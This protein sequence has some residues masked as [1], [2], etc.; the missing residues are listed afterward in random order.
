MAPVPRLLYVGLISLAD[1][2]G[3]VIAEP[4][5]LWRQLF[6]GDAT[7][8]EAAIVAARAEL[9]ASGVV[10]LYTVDGVEYIHHP[11]FPKHQAMNRRYAPLYPLAPEQEYERTPNAYKVSP[12]TATARAAAPKQMRLKSGPSEQDLAAYALLH[13]AWEAISSHVKL[14]LTKTA[15]ERRNKA[16]ALDLLE[17]G[18]TH[19]GVLAMLDVAFTHPEARMFWGKESRS[20]GIDRLDK[21]AEAWPKLEAFARNPRGGGKRTFER[22]PLEG[23]AS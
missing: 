3:N 6:A 21:L 9:V 4:F 12:K 2:P 20:G 7:T 15:W 13:A 10:E 19:D 8:T 17:A 14:A 11:N 16:A 22:L 23:E 18:K 1:D 5:Y